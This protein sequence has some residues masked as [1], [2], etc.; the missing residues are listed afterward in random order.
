M[1]LKILQIS[2]KNTCTRVS[3]LVMNRNYTGAIGGRCSVKKMFLKILQ[4][5]SENSYAGNFIKKETPANV[6]SCEFWEILKF[7]YFEKHL[8]KATS[9]KLLN[10][11]FWINFDIITLNA[12]GGSLWMSYDKNHLSIVKF[13]VH[14]TKKVFNNNSKIIYIS[15]LRD[16]GISGIRPSYTTHKNVYYILLNQRR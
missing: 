2:Q 16:F 7:T 8:R 6:F 13:P 5:S 9:I 4:K 1:F 10:Y 12:E 14:Y 15:L 3:F 11:Q